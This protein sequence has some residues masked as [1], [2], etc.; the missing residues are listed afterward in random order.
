M[1]MLTLTG[2]SAA[3]GVLSLIVVVLGGAILGYWKYKGYDKMT[4]YTRV[5]KADRASSSTS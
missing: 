5:S 3:L 1:G 2:W 4:A